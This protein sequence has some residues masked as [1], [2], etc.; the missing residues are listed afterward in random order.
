MAEPEAKSASP[1][2]SILETPKDAAIDVENSFSAESPY[3]SSYAENELRSMQIMNETLRDISGRTKTFGKCGALMAESTRRLALACR[4]RRP[5]TEEEEKQGDSQAERIREI[6]VAERRRAVGEDMTSLLG[7]MSEMLDEIADAQVQMCQSFEATLVTSLEHFAELELR[8][9]KTLEHSAEQSSETAEQLLSKYLNGRHAAALSSNGNDS[10]D[11]GGNEAWNRF[12]EQVG[13]HGQSLLQRFQNRNKQNGPRTTLSQGISRSQ[14]SSQRTNQAPVDPAVQM[15]STAANLRLTL[16]QVRLAQATAELKR[17]QLLKHIV[18]HK[19]RR[20]FEIGENVLASLHGI[21]AYFH[22][23]SDLVNGIVP[24]MNRFQ[25]EQETARDH[26]EKKLAPSWRARETD[27]EGTIDGLKQ[28]TKSAAIIVEAISNGDKNYV[29]RQVTGLE[30]IEDKVQIWQLPRMLA[31]STRLKR[32]PTPGVLVEGWLYKKS[33]Q[34]ISL[35]PWNKRWF[36]MDANGIYYF[37]SNDDKKKVVEGRTYV[38]SL[39]RV[40]ICDVVLC[41]VREAP[42]E[43]PRF[44]FEVHTPSSKPLMLQARGPLEYK[45]WVDGIRNGIELQLVNGNQNVGRAP[46][47]R[48]KNVGELK[49]YAS[50]S[51]RDSSPVREGDSVDLP[52]FHDIDNDRGKKVVTQ[53][54]ST[55]APK[56]MEINQTC[57]DCGAPNP[58]WVSL[59]L[60]VL[61][62]IE[63][64]GVHRS[65]GVHVS[66]VRS[67]KL[68]ALSESEGKLVL[69]LGNENANA[70]WE[71]GVAM[72][73]GWD[74][75]NKDSGRKP[76]EEWIKSKYLWRGF[77]NH[78]GKDGLPSGDGEEQYCRHMYAAAQKGDVLGIADALA[79]GAT[80]TW[81]NP[82]EDGRTALHECALLKAEGDSKEDWKAIECAELLIQNGAKVDARDRSSHGVLDAA[83]VGDA[84]VEMIEYLTLKSA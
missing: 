14:Q 82:D 21:R 84:E 31:D 63:C 54:K 49:K 44:C 37:R 73:K 72:Q 76:K 40:K 23:C 58:D 8:A 12:S 52:E 16:E 67:L 51:S 66:K 42:N 28:V 33:S 81:Q 65:L 56:L 11:P 77:I 27:I 53:P 10:S 46:A 38:K 30:D 22:H 4:L 9:A 2:K 26:L 34:R 60:G 78:V 62:C 59:N 25:V 45:K 71:G 29:E 6:Q 13:N 80:S 20:K 68:D 5:I 32:D 48:Q 55:L 43:G 24:T 1:S 69:A 7:V 75:P 35:T 57:A 47:P 83:M 79:R 18:A 17:F 64:S 15:A 61:V 36:M 19:Q 74:K 50:S 39:E 70:I 3:F 41:T